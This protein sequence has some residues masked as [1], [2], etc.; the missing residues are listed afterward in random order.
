M[1]KRAI[2]VLL[3]MAALQAMVSL[4]C[5]SISQIFATETPTPT[6]TPTRTPTPTQT[7]TPTV[8]QTPTSTETPTPS[9]TA[10]PLP[11]YSVEAHANGASEYVDYEYGFRITFPKDWFVFPL[12]GEESLTLFELGQTKFED[13]PVD[14][15]DAFESADPDLFR[16]M[17]LDYSP[18]HM[19]EGGFTP[20]A[21]LA[22]DASQV[23]PPMQE[24]LAGYEEKLHQELPDYEIMRN[25]VLENANGI[26]YGRISFAPS[27]DLTS[28]YQDQI[29]FT[30]DQFD[31]V[32]FLTFMAQNSNRED[33]D[34][35]IQEAA[36]SFD[37]LD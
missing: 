33:I 10:T 26:T 23:P 21:Y 37:F 19:D 2:L 31:G 3:A 20:N 6:H 13:S 28:F 7:A 5:T 17:I 32:V 29:I 24:M 12:F 15:R 25:E 30:L 14:V 16:L 8:T 9:P 27:R 11:E 36:D 34:A 18:D 4:S 22:V 1:M 35:A